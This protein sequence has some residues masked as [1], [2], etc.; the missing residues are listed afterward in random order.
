MPS[1]PRLTMLEYFVAR[2]SSTR[3]QK[4]KEAAIEKLERGG[5]RRS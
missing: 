2:P 3:N 1:Q 4:R 5:G